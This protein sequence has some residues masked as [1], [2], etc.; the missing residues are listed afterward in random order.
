MRSEAELKALSR[1]LRT[2]LFDKKVSVSRLANQLGTSESTIYHW[3]RGNAYP[4]RA[5][6]IQL[7]ELLGTNFELVGCK[8]DACDIGKVLRMHRMQSGITSSDLA[9]E[10]DCSQSAITA[11]ES[12]VSSPN[13]KY[14]IRLA[15]FYNLSL[16]EVVGRSKT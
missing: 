4:G 7:N 14:L 10:I 2:V 3:L 6:L 1:Q 5:N 11:W 13:I 12:G 16:D 8:D 9:Q 15:D